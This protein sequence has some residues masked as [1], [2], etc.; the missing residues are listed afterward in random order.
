IVL[1]ADDDLCL[2][3]YS[4]NGKHLIS[5]ESSAR[6]NCIELSSCGELLVCAGDQGQIV[7]RSMKSL[8]ILGRYS[9]A[10]KIIILLTVTQEECV[11]AGKI[12]LH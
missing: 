10:G 2:H 3:L 6:L 5:C 1:Y 11:L 9:G 12:I 4:I 8:E 7:V